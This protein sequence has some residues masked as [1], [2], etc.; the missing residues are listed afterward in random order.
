MNNKTK[1]RPLYIGEGELI[2]GEKGERPAGA[3]AYPELCCHDN[4]D[5]LWYNKKI[6]Y[7]ILQ[8]R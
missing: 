2:L 3:P 7:K 8:R 4:F 5:G 6:K 1:N